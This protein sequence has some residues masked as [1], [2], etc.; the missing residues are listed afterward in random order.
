MRF[1]EPHE[2]EALAPRPDAV[3]ATYVFN[4]LFLFVVLL[5]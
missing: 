3:I 1:P 2:R 4:N 5:T